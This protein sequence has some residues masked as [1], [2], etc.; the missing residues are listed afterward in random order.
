MI[1]ISIKGLWQKEKENNT[2]KDTFIW[3]FFF[4]FHKLPGHKHR[5]KGL[6]SVLM[7]NGFIVSPGINLFLSH[8][9]LLFILHIQYPRILFWKGVAFSSVHLCGW[10]RFLSYPPSTRWL[11]LWRHGIVTSD[12]HLCLANKYKQTYEREHVLKILTEE[13]Y[14][15]TH[16]Y[17][18]TPIHTN[19]QF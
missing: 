11:L 19:K 7:M 4:W 13:N 3:I 10:A 15:C 12:L 5:D 18:Y 17:R 16:I 9:I 1:Y 2:Q 8:L 6:K 14:T